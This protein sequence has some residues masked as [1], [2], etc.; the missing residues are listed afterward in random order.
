RHL[1]RRLDHVIAISQN[2]AQDVRTFFAV[3]P[4]RITAIHNGLEHQR[5]FPAARAAAQALAVQRHGLRQPFFLY[6]ARL[7]HPAKN[8]VRL[9]SAFNEF[10]RAAR[11]PW[12]LVLAGS[13]WH[14]AEFIHAAIRQSPFSAEIRPLGFVDDAHLPAL[15]QAADAFVYPSLYEGFGMPPTEAMACGCPVICSTRGSL[16]EVVGNAAAIINPED[17][18]SII[19]QLTAVAG[20]ASLRQRLRLAGLTHARNFTWEKTAAQTIQVYERFA[21]N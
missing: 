10:K 2:T 18:D 12:Q 19:Q 14:G 1:A 11:S 7:E 21:T 5:F 13:D 4:D 3:P 8:H 20:D 16:G 6:I 17:I 15:Y 9:I